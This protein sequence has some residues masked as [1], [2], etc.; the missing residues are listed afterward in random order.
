MSF[1]ARTLVELLELHT[2]RK[3]E[4][5]EKDK[6]VIRKKMEWKEQAKKEVRE[7]L[8]KGDSSIDLEALEARDKPTAHLEKQREDIS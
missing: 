2:Y 5:E 1:P 3:T 6:E 8:S 4:L 7:A